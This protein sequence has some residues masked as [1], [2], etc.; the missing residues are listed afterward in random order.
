M[1][2]GTLIIFVAMILVASVASQVIIGTV[3]GLQE[4]A[5]ETG[6]EAREQVSTSFKVY[7]VLGYVEG[8]RISVLEMVVGVTGGVVDPKHVSILIV[9]NRTVHIHP[10]VYEFIR[11]S[12]YLAPGELIRI[13]LNLSKY[14]LDLLPQSR[15]HISIVPKHGIPAVVEICTPAVYTSRVVVIR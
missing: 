7:S 9:G 1:G 8:N 12:E 4:S 3:F 15:I 6:D 13:L 14:G 5:L 11:G 10:I 2:V